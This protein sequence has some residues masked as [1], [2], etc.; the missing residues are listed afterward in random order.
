MPRRHILSAAGA[1]AAAL[2]LAVHAP[3]N[4]Q[5]APDQPQRDISGA[6]DGAATPR[7]SAAAGARQDQS[8]DSLDSTGGWESTTIPEPL[9]GMGDEAEPVPASPALGGL[10][11]EPSGAALQPEESQAAIQP[12]ESGIPAEELGLA[13]PPAGLSALSPIHTA[14]LPE[15][16]DLDPYLPI[17]IKLGSFLLFP[18]LEVGADLTNNV[19]DTHFD[20]RSDMGPELKPE[21]APRFRLGPACPELRGQCRPHLVQRLPLCRYQELPVAGAGSARRDVTHASV[22]RDREIARPGK[23]ELDQHHRY[24]QRQHR[25]RR[26]ACHCGARA[27]LQPADSEVHR[28]GSRLRLRRRYGPRTER[29]GAV[30]RY[31][32]LPRHD[33]HAAQHL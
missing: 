23:L 11:D 16:H 22:G 13:P 15:P 3:A 18:E 24:F 25:G 27:Y 14:L 26:A 32:G 1:L 8:A 9:G 7:G 20:T 28:H 10:G 19:L 5:T 6:P 33:R 4:A 30:R 2:V 12:E 17:G 21:S 31:Q 29:P